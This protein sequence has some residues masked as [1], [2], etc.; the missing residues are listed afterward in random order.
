MR[1]RTLCMIKPDAVKRDL[2]GAILAMI[3]A[4]GLKV[5]G[6]KMLRLSK[7]Q[8]EAFY[9]VHSARPFYN[10]LTCYMCSGRIFAVALE[11]ED[12][13]A[14]Y[15]KLMGATDPAKAE[16][17]TIRAK[18]AESLEANSVHGSDSLENAA[19]EVAFF[20]NRLEIA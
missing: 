2:G 15:R 13:V 18:Y 11:G 4:S 12:A 14:R 5:V 3:E 6:L 17:G 20:F 19:V 16:P 1:E 8:A 10:D 9:A 7:A